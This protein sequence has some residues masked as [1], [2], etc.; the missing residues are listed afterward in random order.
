[1]LLFHRAQ[2]Q[3]KTVTRLIK[4]LPAAKHELQ[5]LE[6]RHLKNIRIYKMSFIQYFKQE[7][8]SSAKQKLFRKIY[9]QLLTNKIIFFVVNLIYFQ[10]L[11]FVIF[12]MRTDNF[13]KL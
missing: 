2:M 4:M 6:Y 3:F 1:M 10:M 12:V 13:W 11:Y 5:V 7:L 9:C 8:I